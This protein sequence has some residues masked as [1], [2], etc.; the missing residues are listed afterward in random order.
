[1]SMIE[2]LKQEE[3]VPVVMAD[4]NGLIIYVNRKFQ[5]IFKWS[6][7]EIIGEPLTTI[8]P[9]YLHDA[10][11]LGFSRFLATEKTVI[12]NRPLTLQ[13]IDKNGVIFLAEHCIQSEKINGSWVFA[14]TIRPLEDTPNKP[15]KK[16]SAD[17][18][19]EVPNEKR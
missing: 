4:Q 2:E 17:V 14:A 3:K 19:E 16:Q 8:I 7:D 1:M 11:N 15:G 13:A 6:P 12:L 5:E 9:P 10:H 18:S